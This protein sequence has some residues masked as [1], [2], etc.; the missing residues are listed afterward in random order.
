MI[1]FSKIPNEKITV[2]LMGREIRQVRS[3]RYHAGR[4]SG[5]RSVTC[6]PTDGHYE[7]DRCFSLLC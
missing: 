4:C 1:F 2:R 7:A 5:G 6:G 3:I